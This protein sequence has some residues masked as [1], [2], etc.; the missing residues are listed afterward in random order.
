MTISSQGFPHLMD[1]CDLWRA[2]TAVAIASAIYALHRRYTRPSNK[3]IPGPPNSS[4]IRAFLAQEE[5]L[6]I[7]DPKAT[8]HI[9]NNSCTLYRKQETIREMSALFLDRGLAWADGNALFQFGTSSRACYR[10][11]HNPPQRYA[12]ALNRSNIM[13]KPPGSWQING[14]S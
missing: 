6:W 12:I 5:R 2:A 1:Y 8:N 10:I 13:I 3:D 7:A 9:P 14:T 4:W 11:S